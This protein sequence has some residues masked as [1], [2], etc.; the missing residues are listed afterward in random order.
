M[1]LSAYE[2]LGPAFAAALTAQNAPVPT[3]PEAKAELRRRLFRMMRVKESWLPEI[4]WECIGRR[5]FGEVETETLRF[6]SWNGVYGDATFYLPRQR[7]GKVPAMLFSPGHAF[8]AG[9]FSANY[10]LMAQQC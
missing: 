10:Q 1:S 7:S 8:D 2:K 5:N 6:R 4:R 3:T 9:R